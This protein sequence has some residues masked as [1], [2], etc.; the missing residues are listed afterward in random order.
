MEDYEYKC[1]PINQNLEV[2]SKGKHSD[3]ALHIQQKIC[4]EAT[5]GWEYVHTIATN[6]HRQQGCLSGLIKIITLG[7]GGQSN[8]DTIRINVLVFKKRT[9]QSVSSGSQSTA[10][11]INYNDANL[12]SELDLNKKQLL[13]EMQKI[14]AHLKSISGGV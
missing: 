2:K 11:Q 13:E 7:L 6:A 4:Q 1:V 10:T 5:G 12:I 9:H 3:I 8:S 14:T